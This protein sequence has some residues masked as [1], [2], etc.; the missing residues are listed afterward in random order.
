MTLRSCCVVWTKIV[1][2]LAVRLSPPELRAESLTGASTMGSTSLY[3]FA[4]VHQCTRRTSILEVSMAEQGF[5]L[6]GR[7]KVLFTS[8]TP[9]STGVL[10]VEGAY[11]GSGG[12][13]TLWLHWTDMLD[14]KRRDAGRVPHWK[15]AS[16]PTT[17]W[18]KMLL[19]VTAASQCITPVKLRRK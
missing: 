18:S 10:L 17:S 15:A 2:E 16:L 8:H 13:I 1:S 6:Q 9:S 7:G 14:Q 11:G 19:S 4:L 3:A 12:R 5:R